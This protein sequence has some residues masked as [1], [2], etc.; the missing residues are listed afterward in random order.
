MRKSLLHIIVIGIL[1]SSCTT[2]PP[3]TVPQV[4]YREVVKRCKFNPLPPISL[5]IPTN[6]KTPSDQVFTYTLAAIVKLEYRTK[7]LTKEISQCEN[8]KN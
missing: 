3:I 1:C 6:P 7:E 5:D 2:I 4:Q 8:L